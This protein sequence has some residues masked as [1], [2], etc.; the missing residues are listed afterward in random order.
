[1]TEPAHLSRRHALV[2]LA[3][4][5]VAAACTGKVRRTAPSVSPSSAGTRTTAPTPS[6]SP[7]ARPLEEARELVHGPRTGH[8]VALTF[9]GAG[10]PA[11]ARGLLSEVERRHAQ[12]TILAVGT[13]LS[14]NP[15]MA[16]RI[17]DGGHELGNHTYHHLAMRRLS[18]TQAFD[19]IDRCAATLR[20]L[21]GSPG[22]WFRPSGTPRATSTILRAAAKAGY[23]TSLAYDVDPRDYQDPGADAVVSRTLA[24]VRPGSVVSLHLGHK[25]TVDAMPAILDGLQS[26]GLRAVTTSELFA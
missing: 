12:V 10:D 3:V 22:R 7:S 15:T 26:A 25:G 5:A 1:M 18:A 9:H 24:A 20:A 13:W 2:G 14:A 4:A 19:E 11:L 23:Q 21:S 6:S 8:M 17:L 16:T